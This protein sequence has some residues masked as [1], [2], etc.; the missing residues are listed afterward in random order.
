MSTAGKV[1]VVLVAL[2]TI[3]W[4]IL[5]SMV[6]QLNENWG[7]EIQNLSKAVAATEQEAARMRGELDRTL[8][9]ASSSQVERD[10]Q[11]TVLR[12]R[13]S[14]AEKQNTL[15]AEAQARMQHQLDTLNVAIKAAQT[16]AE[17][18]A[19]EKEDTN[20]ALAD[21]REAV[22]VL[23]QDV[24]AKYQ[25]VTDLQSRF[26]KLMDQSR[27]QLHQAGR[28]GADGTRIRAASLR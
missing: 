5:F 16:A 17:R 27:K 21:T 22:Q 26:R 20:Q 24:D 8:H 23:R 3:P 15:I 4:I 14:D 6:Y 18:R 19:K 7:L 10:N 28:A 2:A 9:E 13:L 25:Q 11:L 12:G 1:L